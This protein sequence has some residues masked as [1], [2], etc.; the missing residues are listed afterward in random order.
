MA[1][2]TPILLLIF[3]RPDT[4]KLVFE[5]IKK[6]APK[7]LYI[8]SDG[9][10]TKK[11]GE[12]DLVKETRE[13]ILSNVDWDCEIHTLFREENIGCK[14]A[15]SSAISW[16]FDHVEYGI[17]IEDDCLPSKS[18]FPFC[19]ELLVKYKDDDRIWHIDGTTSQKEMGTYSYQFSKYCL[20]WGWATW[21][22]AWK[23]YDPAIQ[24]FPE[25]KSDNT[26]N[27][28]WKKNEVRNYWLNKLESVYQGKTDTWDYQWAFTVWVNNGL[29]IR[30]QK[31]L[32]KNIGFNEQATHTHNA[33][34]TLLAANNQEVIFPLKH[35]VFKIVNSKMDDICSVDH[36]DIRK[37]Y[38]SFFVR[39]IR[40]LKKVLS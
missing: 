30:P 28:I 35:P 4:A 12:N 33:N 5:K 26:I 20:I 3:N 22:R 29:S 8:A 14:N 19:E 6:Q 16:F 23:H 18:F 7:Y 24:N 37:P 15:V 36:F 32:I 27:E 10:R 13:H 34:P 17:I 9:P 39:I 2:N 25:F 21:K 11:V 38:Y 31:N 1:F 40:K